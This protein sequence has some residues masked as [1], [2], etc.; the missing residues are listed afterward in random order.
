M[1]PRRQNRITRRSVLIADRIAD[2]T[3]TIGGL[4][5]I[6]AV[7][8]IMV[9]L[10]QVTVP[11]FTGAAVESRR[12]YAMGTEGDQTLMLHI[13]EY[14]T[15]AFALQR[16]G[17]VK[18]V[19]AATGTPLTGA[20]LDFGGRA[21]TAF[22]RTI[23]RDDLIFGFEDGTVRFGNVR[24]VAEIADAG[25]VPA[26]ARRLDER[27][28]TDG[29]RIYSRI[30]GNQVRIISLALGLND[31]V[32]VAERGTPI[33]AADYRVGGTAERPVR[34]FVTVDATGRIRLS[35]AE[36]RMNLMTQRMRT[37]VTN[38]EL[39]ALPDGAQPVA[40][41]LTETADTVLVGTADG[42]V[43]R[44]DSRDFRAPRMVERAAVLT[45]GE[46][47]TGLYY[48]VGEQS[49]VVTGSKGT[50]DVFFLLERRNAR[51]S[52]GFELVRAH[53][54]E[55]QGAPIDKVSASPRSK[56]F[57]TA[58]TEGKVWLRH[59]T[60]SRTLLKLQKSDTVGAYAGLVMAPR[61]D[62]VI[63]LTDGGTATAWWISA[64]HPETTLATLFGRVWYEGY[65]EPSF[66]WQSSSGSDSFEPKLSLVPLI[67]GTVK[68]TV[69]ALLFAVPI[70]LMAAIY[71]SEF[72]HHRVRAV[73]KPAMEMMASL[74]S[75]VLGFIAALILAPIVEDWVSAV[76]MV[77]I[78]V[79]VTLLVA[80]YAWQLLPRHV[81]L[82]LGGLP[83]F[84]LMFLFLFG[85]FQ[86]SLWT[87]RLLE[88]W[89]FAGDIKAWLSGTIGGPT[90]FTTL[91]LMPVM[92][93]VVVWV[94]SRVVTDRLDEAV[95]A[96]TR[97]AAGIVSFA[98][99]VATLL[100]ALL[101]AL[102][103]ASLLTALGYDPRGGVVGTYVQR[104]TL[105]VGF[106]IG[107]AVIPIIYTIAEDA[108]NSVPEH[109]RGASLACGATP[110]QTATRVILPTATSGV[111]A[112]VM[113]GMGRAVG[114][115][116][117]VVMAAGNTPILDWNIFNGL[118]ALSAN[119]AVELPEAVRDGTLYRVLFLAALTLFVMTFVINTLAEVI[120]QQFRRRAASL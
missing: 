71:T 104:N 74:P 29:T 54:L 12:E 106:A 88:S 62:A 26:G 21:V 30:P 110:W 41:L 89:V 34:S 56:M 64:P 25:L 108:L 102:L 58:D 109:L 16:T 96:T 98:R 15:I 60:S 8:G 53:V 4:L 19:H 86:L 69:Y 112:A 36:S 80:A 75:V 1:A 2:R 87:G 115:T 39:P 90:G 38:A 93:A 50:A 22:G 92:L 10:A 95:G 118:R 45:G 24:I 11:L 116:M 47:L 40:V 5:V 117:I 82:R 31:P 27:D 49:L 119:I 76:L 51:G 17:D 65:P 105:V 33:I 66:T 94:S 63:A 13:D 68:A 85:A 3:I 20:R 100:V 52:D 70:A 77:F 28:V 78:A 84:G 99:W 18:I 35:R 57:L 55:N 120:R 14:R 37:T 48:L 81:A 73:V 91:L 23:R 46:R 59:S 103:A 7:F 61:E 44:Y 43:F 79:P 101:L 32:Q 83:K 97:V 42:T 111:F 114:E 107:F 9:F 113:V 67:F 6:V 72:V